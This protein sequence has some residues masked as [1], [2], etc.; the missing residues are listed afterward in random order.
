MPDVC[1][2]LRPYFKGVMIANNGFNP[3]SGLAKLQ[4]GDC[5]AVSYGRLYISNP[6]LAERLVAGFPVN[7]NYDMSTFYGLNLE[8]KS[9]GYTDYPFHQQQ[10]P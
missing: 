5:D 2:A 4:S 3:K 10:Q 6:D 9:K 7:S 8:D 1:K